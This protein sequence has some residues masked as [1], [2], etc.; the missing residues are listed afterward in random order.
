MKLR[1]REV[2]CPDFEVDLDLESSVAEMKVAATAGCDI[3]PDFM[4]VMYK[5]KVLKDQDSLRSSG[6]DGLQP[7]IVARVKTA[8]ASN[9][10][11]SSS[12]TPTP[13]KQDIL[14]VAVK[15][16]NGSEVSVE[17]TKEEL[18]SETRTRIASLF[19]LSEQEIHFVLRGKILKDGD[20]TSTASIL[21]SGD[22]LRIAK[23]AVQAPPTTIT[24]P[25][26]TGYD[27]AARAGGAGM[28]M[29][30]VFGTAPMDLQ[31]LLARDGGG[32]GPD[33][34]YLEM[35]QRQWA[36]AARRQ[37]QVEQVPLEVRLP[38]EVRAMGRQVR[39]LVAEQQ[40]VNVDDV[41]E[42]EELLD[43]IARTM[44][45]ARAR[46]APVPNP[47]FFVS[48]ALARASQRQALHSRL[49]RETGDMDPDLED[50]LMAAEQQS[51]AAT[52]ASRNTDNCD[53]PNKSQAS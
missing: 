38:R 11:A 44:A 1:I 30:N 26:T 31:T 41:E 9:P 5:G 3:D 6:V 15:G 35:L 34:A 14:H 16:P 4:K 28:P 46:L 52:R 42:D 47:R 49:L 45:E 13:L 37:Q 25:Q 20:K 22:V 7:L 33:P 50:A 36:E 18:F 10:E 17:I 24:P 40:G 39:L 43:H 29:P 32:D 48:H 51:L 19:S 23:R 53:S 21:V 8:V 27:P 12:T 2:G